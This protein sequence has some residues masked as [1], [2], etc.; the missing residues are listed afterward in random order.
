MHVDR[1]LLE[2]SAEE[3]FENAPCGYLSTL[4]DGTI[5]QVNQTFIA[6]TGYTREWLL[7]GKRFS[8][9]LTIPGRVYHDTHFGPLLQMQGFIKEVAFDLLRQDQHRLPVL[10]NAHQK[11]TAAS[12]AKLTLITVFDATDRRRYEQELLL[13]RRRAEEAIEAE[14]AAKEKAERAIRTK[15]DFL[16]MISHELRTPLNAILGW[17]QILRIEGGISE[18]QQEGLAVIERNAQVQMELISDLLD[19]SRIASGKMRLNVQDVHL[20]EIIEA[21]LNTARPA[22]DA[23]GISLQRT[24][25]PAVVVA[26]DPGRL[27]QVFWNLLTNAIKFTPKGGW[28]RVVMQRI[29]SHVEINV[30]DSGRGMDQEFLNH[31]FEMFRQADS[32]ETRKST[33]LGLGLSIVKN[34]VEMH[35]GS[36]AALSEGV[37]KGSTFRVNLPLTVVHQDDQAGDRLHPRAALA[38]D[39][40]QVRGMSLEGVKVLVVDDEADA[41]EMVRRVLSSCGAQVTTAASADEALQLL[42]QLKPDVL[43]SDIG[44]AGS[45][46]YELI[47][48]VRM[49]GGGIGRVR[50]VALTAFARLE[51]RTKAMLSGYQMHL[52]KPVDARELIVTIG[53]L[54]GK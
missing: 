4:A 10:V 18:D 2:Q 53:T 30:I 44:M 19:M 27:Q 43:I 1:K 8:E 49:L 32:D 26:G 31:A 16:A 5:I 37:G 36:I 51:D 47:R 33:G 34:L 20:S 14:R 21:A 40:V 25:D 7:S 23:K 12:D 46:G 17:T 29:D 48:K 38:G 45:D 35:G 22:A 39:V 15:D 28:V 24:I 41:R 13:A 3:L 9:L 6:M 50:A 52:T 42:D 11:N 54:A